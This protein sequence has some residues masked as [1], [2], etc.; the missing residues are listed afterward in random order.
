[1][2]HSRVLSLRRFGWLSLLFVFL[3]LTFT[4][5]SAQT[6]PSEEGT[7]PVQE[8]GPTDPVEPT[9]PMDTPP[10][11]HADSLS[12]FAIP[13]GEVLYTYAASSNMWV[14]N[15]ASWILFRGC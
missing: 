7:P 2:N 6:V 4:V 3:L 5:A 11:A 14:C 12:D 1:M 9:E 13:G 15:D 8:Q 10:P